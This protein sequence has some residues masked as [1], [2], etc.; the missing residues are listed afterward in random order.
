M[1]K[2]IVSLFIIISLLTLSLSVN[3]TTPNVVDNADL[4]TQDETDLLEDAIDVILD[5]YEFEVVIV[6]VNSLEGK[7]TQEYADDF[8]D[9]NGYGVDD[10]HSGAL[11]LLDMESRGWYI[12]TTGYG[13]DAIDQNGFYYIEGSIIPYFSQGEYYEGFSEFVDICQ[14]LLIFENNGQEIP[15]SYYSDVMNY[16]EGGYSLSLPKMLLIS[17]AVG[18][19]I[20]FIIVSVMKGKLKTV[21]AKNNATDYVVPGSLNVTHSSDLYLYRHVNK[22]PR[23]QSSSGNGGGTHRGSSGRSH[24]GGGGRF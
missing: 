1:K 13:I 17:V 8:Y 5:E 4:L 22:T 11:L 2:L 15:E 19:I 10:R 24:G 3:A 18:F 14:E 20:A 23:Q 7:T 12:S 16:Y 21:R 6:T 9:Y